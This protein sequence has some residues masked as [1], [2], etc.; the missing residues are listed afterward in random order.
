MVSD[1]DE[2]PGFVGTLPIIPQL[3]PAHGALEL[4][5]PYLGDTHRKQVQGTPTGLSHCDIVIVPLPLSVV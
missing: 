1:A 3:P 2:A 4:L 5:S